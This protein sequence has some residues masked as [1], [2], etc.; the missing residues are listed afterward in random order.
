VRLLL[1][2][3]SA[4][5][6]SACGAVG[7][8]TGSDSSQAA[9]QTKFAAQPHTPAEREIGLITWMLEGTF[10]TI[11]QSPGYAA[12]GGDNTP[13]RLRVAR[14]WPEREGEIWFYL[15]YTDPNRNDAVTRQRIS[16]MVLEGGT[17]IRMIDYAFP[18]DPK[19][20]AG[21]WR[22]P[23]PF[24][25]VNPD[26]LKPIPGCKTHWLVQHQA[27]VSGG[28]GG[29]DCRGDGPE[30]THEHVDWWLGSSFLRTWIQQLDR[31]GKQVGGLS[32]PSEFRRISQKP[33]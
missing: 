14:L 8:S 26:R 7:P 16:R 19:T 9:V 2:A 3:L 12:G 24:A 5:L 25:S 28:T 21:E 22:K 1:L 15:E 10:E 18:A 27:I 20:F 17:D 6:L 31:S 11:V 4:A 33:Q 13:V 30:G 32:G 23:H 29:D